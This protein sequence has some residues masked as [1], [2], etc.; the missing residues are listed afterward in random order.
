MDS[1][2]QLFPG[3]ATRD[4]A[5]AVFNQLLGDCN[6]DCSDFLKNYCKNFAIKFLMDICYSSKQKNFV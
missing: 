6:I 5:E 4:S 1:R 3:V 2:I